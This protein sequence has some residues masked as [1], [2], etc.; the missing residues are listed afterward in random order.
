MS[1]LAMTIHLVISAFGNIEGFYFDKY[2]IR[3][4]ERT[5]LE[6][7]QTHLLSA[8]ICI[9]HEHIS[10]IKSVNDATV[11]RKKTKLSFNKNR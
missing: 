11:M 3:E 10:L 2:L 6:V 7:R 8:L 4:I 9:L 1:W 5:D